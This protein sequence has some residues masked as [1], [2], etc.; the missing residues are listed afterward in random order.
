MPSVLVKK[1]CSVSLSIQEF[2][3]LQ[4]VLL[5]EKDGITDHRVGEG[6]LSL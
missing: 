5:K 6:G 3:V 1:H 2:S 4:M